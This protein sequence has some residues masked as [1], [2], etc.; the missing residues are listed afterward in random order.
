M[1][2][3]INYETTDQPWGG[4]NSFTRSFK[5]YIKEKKREIEILDTVQD[6]MDVFFF[7]ASYAG[8]GKPININNIKRLLNSRNNILNRIF[9]KK[10]YKLIH[11]L[12]GLRATY[13]GEFVPNDELQLK[14]S[15][16]ADF[17]IFQSNE[18][19]RNFQQFGYNKSS[20]SIIYNGVNQE[21]FNTKEKRFYEDGRLKVLS[22]S[23]SSNLMKGFETIADFSENE[24]VESYFVGRWNDDVDKK[25]VRIIP[26]LKR[27]KISQCYKNAHVFLHAAQNDPC[28]NVVLEAMSCG[29]PIIYHNSGGTRELASKY[30]VP[31]PEPEITPEAIE[32][33]IQ[34]I[35]EKYTVIVNKLLQDKEKFSIN[36]VS[37]QYLDVFRRVCN[38]EV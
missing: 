13:G 12:D 4:I 37:E 22:V 2:I 30:G 35:K 21:L 17:T 20:Y 34:Q 6:D 5:E 25:N 28:P 8:P 1:K 7:I 29:L 19:L 16:L 32:N 27:E 18:S 26:P 14:L 15:Q 11:R 31:L 33:I 36:T 38:N 10:N 3:Y 24:N 9:K 23:W